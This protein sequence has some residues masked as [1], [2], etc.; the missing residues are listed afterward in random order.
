MRATLRFEK[1]IL[2]GGMPTTL[3]NMKVKWEY[4]SQDMEN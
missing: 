3:K 1:Y 2:V 4:D